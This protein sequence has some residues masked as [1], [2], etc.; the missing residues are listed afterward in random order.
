MGVVKE[1]NG[2]RHDSSERF[3]KVVITRS[4]ATCLRAEAL[5]RASVAIF[6]MASL[7]AGRQGFARNDNR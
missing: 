4:E 5:R 1:G 6:E 2:V 7:P 3:N